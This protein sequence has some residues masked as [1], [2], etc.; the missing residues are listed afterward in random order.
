MSQR[1]IIAGHPV[2]ILN[3]IGTIE[4]LKP[5][6][7]LVFEAWLQLDDRRITDCRFSRIEPQAFR[8]DNDG[9]IQEAIH[10]GTRLACQLPD[11]GP[12]DLV[13]YFTR[14]ILLGQVKL[15]YRTGQLPA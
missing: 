13:G 14:L 4:T 2:S 1:S 9:L 8:F 12:A 6:R 15:P 3:L 11:A 7:R 5:V 10:T